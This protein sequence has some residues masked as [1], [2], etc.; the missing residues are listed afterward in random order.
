MSINNYSIVAKNLSKHVDVVIGTPGRML[1][2]LQ[3]GTVK[4][5]NIAAFVLDEADQMLDTGFKR[6]LEIILSMLP[7][8]KQTLLFSATLP[9]WVKDMGKKFF[10][11]PEIVDLV[12]LAT[13]ATPGQ[14]SHLQIPVTL[15][16]QRIIVL[17]KLIARYRNEKMLVFVNTKSDCAQ[18]AASPLISFCK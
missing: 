7:R 5:K 12:G 11:E 13:Q 16:L 18:L 6:D 2:F 17:S 10:R 14:V 9:Q 3:E 4:V 15:S 1:H 8:D